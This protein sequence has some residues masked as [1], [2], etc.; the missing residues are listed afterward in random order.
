MVLGIALVSI[1]LAQAW[2]FQKLSAV[3]DVLL[4]LDGRVGALENTTDQGSQ[5][6][7][8]DVCDRQVRR[9]ITALMTRLD[10]SLA[11]RDLSA[12]QGI[13]VPPQG[14]GG[15]A[16]SPRPGEGRPDGPPELRPEAMNRFLD[17]KRRDETRLTAD[18]LREVEE[19]YSRGMAN[20]ETPAGQEALNQ[21]L[22]DYPESN[23][24]ACAAMNLA[25]TKSRMGDYSASQ[26]YLDFIIGPG[27]QGVFRDGT[28]A[29][30]KALLLAGDIAHLAGND[31]AAE[32]YW[33]SVVNDHADE[34]DGQGKLF[35]DKAMAHLK[36]IGN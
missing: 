17:A 31:E 3:E 23:R 34:A 7:K 27:R 5:D 1:L 4:R 29:L 16:V 18:Q 10:S 26:Q 30:P 24:A 13:G 2:H 20:L 19:L 28:A 33:N 25:A 21:L 15:S 36:E 32:G 22:H 14:P 9:D 8:G 35:A 6:G 11:A 12:R